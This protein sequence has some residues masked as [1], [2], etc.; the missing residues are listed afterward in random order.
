[1]RENLVK[2]RQRIANDCKCLPEVVIIIIRVH[3]QIMLHNLDIHT[4][5]AA[6]VHVLI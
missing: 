1:M 6:P 5:W 2:G 3:K 4:L